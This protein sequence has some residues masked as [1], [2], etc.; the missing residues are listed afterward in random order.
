VKVFVI[1]AGLV[2]SA[3]A[4]ALH[5]E[6]SL[7]VLDVDATRVRA[8]GQ[9]YDIV[10]IAADA[11]SRRQL[12][13][14]GVADSELVI[15]CTSRDEVNLVAAALAR[16]EAPRATTVVRTSS[17]EFVEVWREGG[18]DVDFVVSTELETARAVVAA[19]GMPA[20]RRT[21]TFAGGQVQVLEL[22]V[23][24]G[25]SPVVVGRE[26]RRAHVPRDS[27][28]VAVLRGDSAE[29]PQAGTVLRP[30]DRVVLTAT[31]DAAR[32]W[33]RLVT[34]PRKPVHDVVVFGAGMLG[35]PIALA[36]HAEGIG[37]RVLEPDIRRAELV[38]E[39]LGGIRVY[40]TSGLDAE[41]LERERIGSA[42]AGVYTMRED[43][44]NLYAAT[45]VRSRGVPFSIALAHDQVS[46]EVYD[47]AGIDVAVDP[48]GV[49]A[50]EIVRFAHDPRTHQVVM[51][52]ND[53]FEIL[54]V[55]TR[56]ESDF[57]GLKIGEMPV[58]GALIGA[59]VRDGQAIFPH[60]EE[61]LRAGDRV[62]VFTESARAGEVERLL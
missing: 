39:R 40:A 53:R 61:V 11:A 29:L 41:F 46:A 6:H 49:T 15:A 1:G 33:C 52:E 22:D 31:P 10:T 35:V 26:L 21:D 12:D 38:A 13:A 42:D 34:P 23:A 2:G 14:A 32:E 50:E 56:P 43:A 17:A 57:V 55:T 24:E 30:G 44:V 54:D 8:L 36:L 7:T 18:L 19:V 4:D 47:A 9:R 28:V 25:A 59:I 16:M 60:G 62:I 51:L 58:R 27:R 45:L 5:D 37:V 3:V 20:A 48:R